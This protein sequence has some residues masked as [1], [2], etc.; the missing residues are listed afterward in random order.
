M[1]SSSRAKRGILL[2]LRHEPVSRAHREGMK[3]P[4]EEKSCVQYRPWNHYPYRLPVLPVL[5]AYLLPLTLSFP[6]F[7]RY[8]ESRTC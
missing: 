3:S 5:P 1:S 2:T 4:R 6:V 8:I 7:T